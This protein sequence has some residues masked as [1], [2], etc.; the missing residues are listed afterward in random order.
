MAPFERAGTTP[1]PRFMSPTVASSRAKVL[2]PPVK[3]AKHDNWVASAVKRVGMSR[4]G[5]GTPRSKKEGTPCHLNAV[6]MPD[7]VSF[8][9]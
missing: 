7:K 3:A 6:S 2:P 8:S 5:E 4:N 9:C 1:S